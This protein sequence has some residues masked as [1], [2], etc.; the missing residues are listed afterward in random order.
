MAHSRNGEACPLM[1]TWAPLILSSFIISAIFII[2]WVLQ[3][4]VYLVG[5]QYFHHWEAPRCFPSL[6][7]LSWFHHLTYHAS[8]VGWVWCYLYY[9]SLSGHHNEPCCCYNWFFVWPPMYLMCHFLI[10]TTFYF[11]SLTTTLCEYSCWSRVIQNPSYNFSSKDITC[12]FDALG[13]WT[14]HGSPILFFAC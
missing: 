11:H 12:N 14:G 10:T 5:P 7:E 8:I 6:G 4:F 3:D 1:K 13:G 2:R 9:P